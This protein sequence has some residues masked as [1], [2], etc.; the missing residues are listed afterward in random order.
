MKLRSQQ[1]AAEAAK[2]IR[3]ARPI[4]RGRTRSG[5]AKSAAAAAASAS[6]SASPTTPTPTT[7]ATINPGSALRSESP[8][9]T[10]KGVTFA[11]SPS[12]SGNTDSRLSFASVNGTPGSVG[13]PAGSVSNLTC[14]YSKF[15]RCICRDIDPSETCGKCRS[16]ILFHHRCQISLG[17]DLRVPE[18][19][20]RNRCLDC[21]KEE[22]S[23]TDDDIIQLSQ[24]PKQ[25]DKSA[26]PVLTKPIPFFDGDNDRLDALKDIFGLVDVGSIVPEEFA[27]SDAQRLPKIFEN[28]D[29][30]SGRG[31]NMPQCLIKDAEGDFDKCL[32]C[33]WWFKLNKEK[34]TEAFEELKKMYRAPSKSNS[35]KKGTNAQAAAAINAA[36]AAGNAAAS[37]DGEEYVGMADSFE[38][39]AEAAKKS[40][41]YKNTRAGSKK[42]PKLAPKTNLDFR[43]RE[44]RRIEEQME[45]LILKHQQMTKSIPGCEARNNYVLLQNYNVKDAHM[46][47][48]SKKRC[49]LNGQPDPFLEDTRPILNAIATKESDL[50]EAVG[51]HEKMAILEEKYQVHRF[52]A[53]SD[54]ELL[55]SRMLKNKAKRAVAQTPGRGRKRLADLNAANEEDTNGE[56]ANGSVEEAE[57]T[58]P[59]TLGRGKRKRVASAKKK[60][61]LENISP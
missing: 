50:I 47:G 28:Y 35:P 2:A 59:P 6:A 52:F 16:G 8:A 48:R 40:Y 30:L 15:D 46:R 21:F 10:A 56:D 42:P 13:S 12:A 54:L 24:P 43:R 55:P 17:E 5:A 7:T 39:R 61:T 32:L 11:S 4:Q 14:C 44:V 49:I 22:H 18:G 9:G 60:L 25:A 58:T 29:V 27:W 36:R 57:E 20:M 3:K 38:R 34:R 26:P 31:R 41:S 37:T 23:I 53:H 19:D 45:E 1:N 33:I 51:G